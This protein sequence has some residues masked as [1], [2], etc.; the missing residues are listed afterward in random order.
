MSRWTPVFFA[1]TAVILAKLPAMGVENCRVL[2]RRAQ[3]LLT[4]EQ[5]EEAL[6]PLLK[7]REACPSNPQTYDL[8]GIAY[9]M[10]NRFGEAQQAHRKAVALS[11]TWP[12]YHNNLAISYARAGKSAEAKTEFQTALRF[13]PHNVLANANLA[14]FCLQENQYRQALEHL[15]TAH[16]DQSTDPSLVYALAKAYFRVGE[17]KLGLQ[18]V[19]RLSGFSYVDEKMRFALGLLLAENHQYSE[20]VKQ[21]EATPV[22]DRDFAVWQNLGLAYSRMRQ[23]V[24]AQRAFDQALRFDPSNPE[25]YFGM[26]L[27]LLD[28][29]SSDQAVY[30]LTQAHL[31]APQRLDVTCALVEALIQSGDFVRA[32][33]LLGEVQTNIPANAPLMQALGDLYLAQ[34]ETSKALDSYQR[35]LQSD[36]ENLQARLSL[37]KVYLR[38]GQSAQ[39]KMAFEGVLR[40]HPRNAEANAG[41]GRI[42]L[43]AGQEDLA[44]Q[45][46]SRALREDAEELGANEDLATIKIR[47]GEFRQARTLLETLV[48]LDPNN[49]RYHYQLGRVLLKLGESEEA[50][51]EFTRSEV[52]GKSTHKISREP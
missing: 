17:T 23:H 39:A 38:L 8:L 15:R 30:S 22:Q 52:I 32:Q 18:T 28:A 29:R 27:D 48:R 51:Q 50:Q 34:G 33:E 45:E 24:E 7:A 47:R 14:D 49:A 26:G 25:P 16:A 19:A 35:A 12:G 4:Q 43:L 6:K 9:D 2:L 46:L 1:M 37:A 11:P 44:L 40:T 20:A 13:D 21:F 42:A 41:L 10:Q 5:S 36:P 3:E 31:K